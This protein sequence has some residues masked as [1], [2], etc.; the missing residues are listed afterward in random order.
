MLKLTSN[1]ISWITYTQIKKTKII[2]HPQ[3]QQT[4]LCKAKKKNLEWKVEETELSATKEK[5]LAIPH[6]STTKKL[7]VK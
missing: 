7:R 6:L 2:L 1:L 3:P 4:I 5:G